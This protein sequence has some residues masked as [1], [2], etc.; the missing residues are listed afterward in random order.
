MEDGFIYETDSE[1]YL[2]ALEVLILL[3]MEDG[4]IYTLRQLLKLQ[5]L[6]S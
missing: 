2:E 6:L 5:K 4:F 3:L 1:G